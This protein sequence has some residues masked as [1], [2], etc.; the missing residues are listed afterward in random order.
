MQGYSNLISIIHRCWN[1]ARGVE[2]GRKGEGSYCPAGLHAK[3]D[4]P[5]L[6]YIP[7]ISTD[8]Q[9]KHDHHT[10]EQHLYAVCYLISYGTREHAPTTKRG[11]QAADRKT[12]THGRK[13]KAK[14]GG[15]AK[16]PSV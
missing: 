4:R 10:L 14:S 12:E 5:T 13:E 11:S 15:S 8:Q 6:A 7:L 2:G 3:F 9:S 1:S 16:I